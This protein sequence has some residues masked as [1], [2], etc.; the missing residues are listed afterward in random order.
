MRPIVQRSSASNHRDTGPGALRFAASRLLQPRYGGARHLLRPEHLLH[1][2][3]CQPETMSNEA[4]PQTVERVGSDQHGLRQGLVRH[5][6]SPREQA[7]VATLRL[8]NGPFA[9][10]WPLGPRSPGAPTPW[11]GKAWLKFLRTT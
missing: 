11:Y 8:S 1:P 3:R 2:S 6:G 7:G 10:R 4:L 9:G 5:E